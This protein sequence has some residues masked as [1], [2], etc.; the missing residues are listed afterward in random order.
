M[1]NNILSSIN[2]NGEGVEII[3]NKI[4]IARPLKSLAIDNVNPKS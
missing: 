4:K 3:A 2:I 1:K